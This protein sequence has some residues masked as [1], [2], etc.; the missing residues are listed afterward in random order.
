MP[1]SLLQNLKASVLSLAGVARNIPV[2]LNGDFFSE[3]FLRLAWTRWVLKRITSRE[4]IRF[5]TNADVR[6]CRFLGGLRQIL[7]F[8]GGRFFRPRRVASYAIFSTSTALLSVQADSEKNSDFANSESSPSARPPSPQGRSRGNSEYRLSVPWCLRKVSESS[9]GARILAQTP[10]YSEGT[11]N[12][13]CGRC[14]CIRSLQSVST[15]F[16]LVWL[17]SPDAKDRVT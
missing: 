5:Q 8:V 7:L 3:V 14:G 15:R 16:L 9:I 1:P 6:F 2:C 11:T 13:L 10:L 17:P 4:F 12:K